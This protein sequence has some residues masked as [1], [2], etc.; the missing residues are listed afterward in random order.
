MWKEIIDMVPS[1]PSHAAASPASITQ[2]MNPAIPPADGSSPLSG[3]PS[4]LRRKI[5]SYWLP[6]RDIIIAA[7]CADH[8]PTPKDQKRVPKPNR[9]TD[10]MVL[11]KVFKNEI[12]EVL[13]EERRFRVDVHPELVNGGIE[14]IDSGR[15]P[16][17]YLG[18]GSGSDRRFERFSKDR[19]FGFSRLK[20]ISIIVFAPSGSFRHC[21]MNVYYQNMALVRLLDRSSK[22]RI[23]Q[24]NI[25]LADDH[26]DRSF[27]WDVETNQP[28]SSSIHG[29]TTYECVL[30]PFS[31]LS[32]VHNVQIAL[33]SKL[34]SHEPALQFARDLEAI[35]KGNQGPGD[36]NDLFDRH[37]L[38]MRSEFEEYVFNLKY[39]R[40]S[41][42]PH[43]WTEAQ[44]QEGDDSDVDEDME[45]SYLGMRQ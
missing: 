38:V 26:W 23:V 12:T 11:C 32:N 4:E 28:R 24:L 21:S 2:A 27:W 30:R 18:D 34:R 20:K 16:L 31:F 42:C 44:W 15:L 5:F 40:S 37:T 6:P 14:F 25:T 33:P 36:W 29:T 45:L 41:E 8:H 22:Q 9:T 19:E 3:I 39:H 43:N 13:Y 17:Q 1:Q 10:L 7:E 35:M